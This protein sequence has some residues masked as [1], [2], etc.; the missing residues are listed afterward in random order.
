MFINHCD[1]FLWEEEVVLSLGFFSLFWV[2][3]SHCFLI[4]RGRA[5]VVFRLDGQFTRLMEQGSDA[6]ILLSTEG[7]GLGPTLVMMIFLNF[8]RADLEKFMQLYIR[9]K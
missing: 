4:F 9:E 3:D 6:F 2:M 7:F 5:V 8:D 1:F